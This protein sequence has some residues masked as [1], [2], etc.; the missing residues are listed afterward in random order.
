MSLL[1]GGEG[2]QNVG[3]CSAAGK[4]R[5]QLMQS[6]ALEW[7]WK[8]AW[9]FMFFFNNQTKYNIISHFIYIFFISALFTLFHYLFFEGFFNIKGET[10]GCPPPP[11]WH[12]LDLPMS[13]LCLYP[14][15]PPRTILFSCQ[16][17]LLCNTSFGIPL[18]ISGHNTGCLSFR[19]N[20]L[21]KWN[22]SHCWLNLIS[23]IS[24]YYLS[25]NWKY[26]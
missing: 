10:G 9:P 12:I 8:I 16:E 2:L 11:P 13:S 24:M 14:S 22:R 1:I 18:E 20:Y 7:F 25:E 15:P 26:M 17:I 19:A 23:S 3:I 21:T 5:S 4:H 6:K